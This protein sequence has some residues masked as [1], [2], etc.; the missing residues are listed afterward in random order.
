MGDEIAAPPLGQL[1]RPVDAPDV[2]H[3]EGHKHGSQNHLQL[4]RQ[5]QRRVRLSAPLQAPD[6]PQEIANQRGE[7]RHGEELEN[8]AGDH[9]VRPRGRV[10]VRLLGRLRCHAA[11]DCLDHQGQ[12]VAGAK[13]D[14]VPFWREDG[15]LPTEKA[16]E[17]R[18][19]DVEGRRV[20]G[21]RDDQ[22]RDLHEEGILVVGA[23]G[24]PG[25]ACPA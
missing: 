15:G 11:A 5:Q 20:K 18:Q 22:R 3:D 25:A 4:P 24:G 2:N 7:D 23:A 17:D 21:W 6:P 12:D 10:P 13:D 9:G 16:D 1:D 19:E 8:D 14:C